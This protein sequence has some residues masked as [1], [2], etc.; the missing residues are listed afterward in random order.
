MREKIIKIKTNKNFLIDTVE[1][2]DREPGGPRGKRE[3]LNTEAQEQM[4]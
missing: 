2:K 3:D 4:M 1:K